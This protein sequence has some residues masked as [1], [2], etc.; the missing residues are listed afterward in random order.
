MSTISVKRVLRKDKMRKDG[1]APIWIRVTANRKSRY[2]ATGIRIEPKHWNDNKEEVR[3][4]HE[5]ADAYN[6]ELQRQFLEASKEALRASSAKQVKQAVR[7]DSGSL[8]GYFQAHID[9]LDKSGQ[10]WEWKKYRVT[11]GKLKECF[12][13]S[14]SFDEI[15]VKALREFE[16]FCRYTKRNAVNTTRK[17]LGRLRRVIRQAEKDGEVEKNPFRVY[18]MP[19][20]K[21]PDRRKLTF[22]TIQKLDALDLTDDLATARD[23]FVFAFYARG[24]RFGDLCCLKVEDVRG[25]QFE[26]TM[27]KT[28]QKVRGKLPAQA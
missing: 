16:K 5:L 12:G 2:L 21:K 14:I 19:K 11:L 3:G 1:T 22:K 7:G 9:A 8:T 10:F 6:D 18:D 24:M 23:A 13:E 15:D 4:G 20:R 26:Y 28:G 17:E 25:D 27:M